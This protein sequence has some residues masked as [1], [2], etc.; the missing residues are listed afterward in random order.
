MALILAL[1]LPLGAAPNAV[2]SERLQQFPEW[3]LPAPLP[4]PRRGDLEYPSWF[5]GSWQLEASDGVSAQVRFKRRNDG[6]VVG[7]RAGNAMAIGA[8]VL[9]DALL[10]VEDDPSN[11]NRQLARFSDERQLDTRIT[12]RLSEQPSEGE[13]LADELSLQ[14]FKQAGLPPRSSRIETLSRYELLSPD[15]ISGEQWQASYGSPED[16]LAASARS[17]QRISLQLK[18]LPEPQLADEVHNGAR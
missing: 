14:L 12:G 16:G 1:L 2:L 10:E 7:E 4:R 8:A 6:A 15:Q 5:E 18:R 13:F 3:Q 9:G 17:S 11:P